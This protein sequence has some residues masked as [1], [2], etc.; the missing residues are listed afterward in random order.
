[1]INIFNDKIISHEFKKCVVIGDEQ[2][3]NADDVLILSTVE[4]QN[5]LKK[6]CADLDCANN[7]V[8]H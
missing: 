1:M 3:T 8:K 6:N 7:K 2:K 4:D 5:Q